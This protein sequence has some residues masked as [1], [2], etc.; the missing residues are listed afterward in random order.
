[1]ENNLSNTRGVASQP[2]TARLWIIAPVV[3]MAFFYF[4]F[5]DYFL[6]LY[7]GALEE[8]A[9]AAGGRFP[10]DMWS[11]YQCYLVS[12]WIVCPLLAGLI[13][14]RYGERRIWSFAQL[15][16]L[17]ATLL[18]L[19]CPTSS[20]ILILACWIGAASVLVWVGG[21]SLVQVVRPEKKGLANAVMLVGLGVGSLLAPICG[22][23]MLYWRELG[24]YLRQGDW[25]TFW[26]SALSFREPTITPGVD[27]CY[28]ILWLLTFV[29]AVCG[30][31]IGLWGQRPGRFEHELPPDWSQTVRD[32]GRLAHNSKFW[33]LVLSL[34]FFGG[35]VFQGANQFLPYR[36]E[37][38]GL[39][40]GAADL[41]WV[42]LNLLKTLIWIPGGFAVG[43]LAGRRARPLA[44]ALM[45]GGF[46]LGAFGMG[47]SQCGWQLFMW[48]AL[49]ELCRQFMRWG[50]SGYL[51]EHLPDDLRATVI[52][53]SVAISGLSSTIFAWLSDYWWN[54]TMSSAYPMYA[55]SICGAIGCVAMLILDRFWRSTIEI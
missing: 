24:E 12:V 28:S 53:C 16:L 47:L 48:V 15:A 50:Q 8:R 31:L 26:L 22:R 55:A 17:P 30:I 6:P 19:Y 39:K 23:A 5:L 34:S 4:G 45:I 11:K 25:S 18:L 36:A 1:M 38:V 40:H 37:D 3:V 14:R 32:L 46:A 13:S 51:S 42:W 2:G 43:M 35:A 10:A 9:K 33:V 49:L 29:T 27:D 20:V 7:F 44:G 21:I 54:P 41:G 52:G